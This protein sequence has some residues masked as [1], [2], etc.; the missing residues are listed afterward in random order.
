MIR[1][2]DTLV[3]PVSG[4]TITFVET[5]AE[6]GGDYTVIECAVR[7]GGGVP[8]AHVH[9]N[10]SETFEVLEASSR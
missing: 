2:G 5:A 10:Q 7:P 3:N 1:A 8:M 4:E 9:P 6:T